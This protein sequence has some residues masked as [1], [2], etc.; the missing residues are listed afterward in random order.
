MYII[1][2]LY[3][4]N[5][6]KYSITIKSLSTYQAEYTKELVKFNFKIKYK[7]NKVNPINI[8]SWRLDYAKG[9]KNSSKRTVLNAI[10]PI[11]Q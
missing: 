11:L 3:N 5:N 9:F 4:Y 7:L 1:Y 8:L 6:L 10:L 2:I